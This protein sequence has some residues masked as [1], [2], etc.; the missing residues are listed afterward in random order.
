MLGGDSKN[1]EGGGVSKNWV[2]NKAELK[3]DVINS[4]FLRDVCYGCGKK[5]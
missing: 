3:P 1:N 4:L 5:E 2:K